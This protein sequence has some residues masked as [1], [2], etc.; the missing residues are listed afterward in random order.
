MN[1][2]K[3]GDL[4]IE[5]SEKYE[6]QQAFLFPVD[7]CTVTPV[8]YS[9][10]LKDLEYGVA[11]GEKITYQRI[12]II[13]YNSYSWILTAFSLL[14]C[15]KSLILLDPGLGKQ[16]LV[17]LLAYTDTEC[18]MISPELEDELEFLRDN[19]H[20][21]RFLSVEQA[22]DRRNL[23]GLPVQGGDFLCFTSGTSKSSKGVVVT[24]EVF[25]KHILLAENVLPGKKAD[26]FFLPLPLHH[27]YALTMIFHIMKKGAVVCLGTTPRYLKQEAVLFDADIAMLVPS[28]IDF[29]FQDEKIMPRLYAVILGGSRFRKESADKIKARGIQ[30]VNIYGSSETAGFISCNRPGEDEN[31]LRPYGPIQFVLRDTGELGV[32]LP[33]C[34]E[35]YYKRPEDTE[36]VLEDGC[37]WTGDA[38]QIDQEGRA[39]ILGRIRDTIVIENGEKIHAEDIDSA[40]NQIK[41]VQEA[42]VVYVPQCG[43]C[44]VIVVE[45]DT[46]V[47]MIQ[48]GIEAYNRDCTPGQRIRHIW[49]REEKLPRTAT[50]KLKRYKLENEYQIWNDS[51]QV[52]ED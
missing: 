15:G 34:M 46:N 11:I 27:M 40:L 10:F 31:W 39:M 35:G 14:L 12:A 4:L 13:G 5:M 48:K 51:C 44:A 41:G 1:S 28:M 32:K 2:F 20:V 6:K 7:K 29:L 47:Q 22:K 37:F 42:A 38:G 30:I 19:Y 24:A 52:K 8:R 21:E 43:I 36:L 18:L 50:G 45:P 23:E 25:V 49:Y 16:D 17:H 26:R 33:F 9:E 3:L